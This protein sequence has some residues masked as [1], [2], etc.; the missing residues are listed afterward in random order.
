VYNSGLL[1]LEHL[2]IDPQSE[3]TWLQVGGLTE[4]YLALQQGAA[5]GSV[6]SGPEIPRAEALGFITLLNLDEV[7]PLPE[8]GVATTVAKLERQREQVRRLLR[9]IVRALQ[10]AKADREGTLP[11]T[12]QFLSLTR[13]EAAQAYDGVASAYS[14]DGTLSERSLRF[15]IDAEKRQLG[16]AE[17]I[18]AARVVDFGPLY[19]VLGEMG[20]QPAPGSAR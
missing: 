14:D 15:T 6:F 16:I 17:E 1:A 10:Y 18:P 4:R 5:Q 11:V 8:S 3:V 7:A 20:I 2:G 19:E 9:A 13:E 12:M